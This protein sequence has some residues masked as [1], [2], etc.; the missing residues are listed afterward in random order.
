MGKSKAKAKNSLVT[1]ILEKDIS[2]DSFGSQ[3]RLPIFKK[4]V[5][6]S[7]DIATPIHPK[8]VFMPVGRRA[9]STYNAEP[10]MGSIIW[11]NR[12]RMDRATNNTSI[13]T[14][15]DHGTNGFQT[16]D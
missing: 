15:K 1:K 6:T 5:Y 8:P 9:V 10:K 3:I 12:S 11:K 16:Q 4:S 7:K 13:S 14:S 2:K